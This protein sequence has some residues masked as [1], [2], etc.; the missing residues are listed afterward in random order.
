MNSFDARI[1]GLNSGEFV[2][3]MAITPSVDQHHGSTHT[4]TTFALGDSG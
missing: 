1:D 4:G 2:L 3:S